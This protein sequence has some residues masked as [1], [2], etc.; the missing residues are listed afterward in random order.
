MKNDSHPMLPNFFIIGAAKAGT[1][2][3]FHCLSQHPEIFMCPTKEIHFFDFD[4]ALVPYSGPVKKH[5][6][7]DSRW[8]LR[9]YSLLFAEANG[10]HAVGEASP[11]YL[12]SPLAAT[13]IQ[14]TIP[15]AR[16]IAILRQ[17]AERAYSN[18]LFAR[19]NL[20]V[21]PAASFAEALSREDE[22]RTNNWFPGF[23]Y[24]SG[25]FYYRQLQEYFERFTR[26]QIKVYLYEEW[27]REPLTILRDI[28]RF[29]GVNDGFQPAIRRD[30]ATVCP[31]ISLLH[32]LVTPAG[33]MGNRLKFVPEAIREPVISSLQRLN[34][35][36][37]T[38]PPPP[39][40]PGIYQELTEGYREDILKL[41]G[42]IGRDLSHWLV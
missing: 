14:E 37:N 30:N 36:F 23:L 26:E 40:P 35:T 21:E 13:R 25:G 24:R 12:R 39:M 31:R 33:K 41:E 27:N 19:F 6:G 10:K 8:R 32:R 5:F 1:T 34:R 42:S 9:D 2:A 18:Y 17:P 20:G 29:L 3:L 22:R 15:E 11:T 38:A 28:F 7:I 4:Q 16:L